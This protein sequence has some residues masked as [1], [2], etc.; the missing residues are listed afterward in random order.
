MPLPNIDEP[1]DKTEDEARFTLLAV[2][3]EGA[4]E[5]LWPFCSE[6]RVEGR[7]APLCWRNDCPE[8]CRR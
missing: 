4:T 7:G 3:F 2:T 5:S 8:S 6:P 1:G